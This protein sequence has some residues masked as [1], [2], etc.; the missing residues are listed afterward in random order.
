MSSNSTSERTSNLWCSDCDNK[1]ATQLNPYILCD[2]C[3]ANRYSTQIVDGKE[4]PFKELLKASLVA[5]GLWIKDGE[6]RQ[7][8]LEEVQSHTGLK[9]NATI[10][11][12]S[13]WGN[14]IKRLVKEEANSRIT[15]H[16]S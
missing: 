6:T 14:N 2:S 13:K 3:Y 10:M 1:P 16:L 9:T 11:E 4:I 7:P 8:T 12:S 15:G 5:Q